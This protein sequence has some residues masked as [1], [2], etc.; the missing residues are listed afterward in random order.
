MKRYALFFTLMFVCCIPVKLYAYEQ[1]R[2]ST[3]VS[4]KKDAGN[5]IP[6]PAR[7][8]RLFDA[9]GSDL[10]HKIKKVFL[11]GRQVQ[12]QDTDSIKAENIKSIGIKQ[13]ENGDIW[14]YIETNNAPKANYS[15]TDTLIIEQKKVE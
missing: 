15:A 12:I 9:S 8:G 4:G 14:E 7:K 2:D 5:N 11:N 3:V 10:T 1:D 6:E 13:F